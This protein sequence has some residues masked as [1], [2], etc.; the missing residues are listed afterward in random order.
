MN[1]LKDAIKQTNAFDCLDC[2]KCT[3][4]CPIAQVNNGYSPRRVVAHTRLHSMEETRRDPMLW[5]CLTCRS[6]EAGCPA[7]VDYSSLTLS[8]RAEAQ[9]HGQHGICSHGGALQALM[10]VMKS[11]TLQQNRLDWVDEDLK[12]AETGEVLFFVGCAPYFDAFFSDLATR[13]L[14]GARSTIKLLNAIGITPALMPQ[15]RCCG[16][17]L[18]WSGDRDS[19]LKLGEQNLEHISQTGAKKVVFFCPECYR[20]VKQ[21]YADNFGKLDFET[22]HISEVISEAVANQKLY[23]PTDSRNTKVTFQDPCRLGRHLQVYDAPRQT[24]RAIPGIELEEMHKSG[25]RAVCCGV[26]HWMNCTTYSKQ[27]QIERLRQAKATGAETL[28]TACPKCEVHLRCAM[29]DLN[30]GED[31]SIDIK[32]V[33]VLAAEALA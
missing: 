14:D 12:I 9:E 20:T 30:L 32:D 17:D 11:D 23:F 21:D 33:T 19:F 22:C 29:Q 5:A 6:C 13:T 25:K 24:M 16:H 3:A 31:I 2:G 1:T 7:D 26:S 18:L 10:R 15:E 27:I 28:I 8:L 4:S